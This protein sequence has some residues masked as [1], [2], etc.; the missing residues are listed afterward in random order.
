MNCNR[1]HR[2]AR[3]GALALLCST[4]GCITLGKA[5]PP[6]VLSNDPSDGPLACYAECTVLTGCESQCGHVKQQ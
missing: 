1:T 4:L 3:L 2:L 6:P 5:P